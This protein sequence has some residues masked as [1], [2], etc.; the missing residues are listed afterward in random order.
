LICAIDLP[1]FI[2]V[3]DFGVVWFVESLFAVSTVELNIFLPV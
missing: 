1:E 2:V 3:V